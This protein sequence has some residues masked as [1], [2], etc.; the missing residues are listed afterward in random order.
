MSMA[1][2]C[3]TSDTTAGH[4][5]MHYVEVIRR[6]PPQKWPNGWRSFKTGK[7]RKQKRK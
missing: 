5:P 7:H 2:I 1:I 3:P 4:Y 6:E